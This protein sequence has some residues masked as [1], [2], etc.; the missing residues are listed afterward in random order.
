MSLLRLF[1]LI[2]YTEGVSLDGV[3]LSIGDWDVTLK[4]RSVAEVF[5]VSQK[6]SRLQCKLSIHTNGT[7]SLR[8]DILGDEVPVHGQWK[9]L[10]NPYCATDR[11]YDSL[12]LTSKRRILC[13]RSKPDDIVRSIQLQIHCRLSGHFNSGGLFRR[14][15]ARLSHGLVLVDDRAKRRKVLAS[16]RSKRKRPLDRAHADEYDDDSEPYGY[17]GVK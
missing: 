13:D 12:C 11:F 6:K 14:N 2:V 10:K 3:A 8:P 15:T 16:F 1:L 5:S 7:F 17:T 4:G 9:L